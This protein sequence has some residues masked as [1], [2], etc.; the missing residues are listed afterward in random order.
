M[1]DSGGGG[2]VDDVGDVWE[3]GVCTTVVDD[4]VVGI[5]GV[6]DDSVVGFAEEEDDCI[7]L[8]MDAAV[9]E[10]DDS[11]VLLLLLLLPLPTAL[12]LSIECD[13]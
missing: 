4:I 2:G 10:S 6:T 5:V 3:V 9:E 7:K 11:T 1:E 8:D 13:L 12:L